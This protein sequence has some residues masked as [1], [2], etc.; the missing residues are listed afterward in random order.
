[1]GILGKIWDAITNTDMAYVDNPAVMTAAGHTAKVSEMH[2]PTKEERQLGD[3]LSKIGAAGAA[4]M[5]GSALATARGVS[6]AQKAVPAITNSRN[7]PAV[8]NGTRNLP[9]V[10][11]RNLP[12]L[13]GRNVP[14]TVNTGLTTAQK[15]WRGVGGATMLG[16]PIASNFIDDQKTPSVD[17]SRGGNRGGGTTPFP[18]R[19]TINVGL[20]PNIDL[21]KP[22]EEPVVDS[23]NLRRRSGGVRRPLKTAEQWAA[24]FNTMKNGLSSQQM[25]YLDSMGI[26]MSNAQAMQASIN[27]HYGNN[28]LAVDNKWGNKSQGALNELL[29]GMPADYVNADMREGLA[30]EKN[31]PDQPVVDAPDPFGYKTSNTYE[32][33]DFASRMKGMGI[34]SNADL[35]N[36][37]HNSGKA[38]WKG[39]AWQTQFRS[40]VDKALGGDYSDANIRKTF[41][42]KNGWGGGFLGGGDFADFQNALQTNAGV[43]NGMY[44]RKQ[45]EARMDA[46]RQQLAA[47]RAQQ[48][49]EQNPVKLKPLQMPAEMNINYGPMYYK[50]SV[51]ASTLGDAGAGTMNPSDDW[52]QF[53]AQ[54]G[55]LPQ[56]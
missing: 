15:F 11:G 41:H 36:F 22:A 1:M 33:N 17:F 6:A 14:S 46:A 54:S 51:A 3:N 56:Q 35:I 26:D 50:S 34:K 25:M 9:T 48:Y 23:P 16:F 47:K 30:N 19:G 44:D 20:D 10:A 24:D 37:M 4:G 43:W 40:D 32:G 27:K 13:V 12:A 21:S 5:A 2:A 38:G 8:V 52:M 42:T 28:R 45:E 7:L 53:A 29:R 18:A 49:T 31:I 39:D 55:Y